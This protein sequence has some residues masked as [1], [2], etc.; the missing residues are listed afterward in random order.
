LKDG[1]GASKSTTTGSDGS[2]SIDA[3]G[4][5]APF[6]FEASG[7]IGG[8]QVVLHSVAESITSSGKVVANITPL[9]DAVV[10]NVAGEDSSAFFI[11]PDASKVTAASISAAQA[12]I[13][14]ALSS[15]LKAAGLPSDVDLLKTTFSADKTGMDAVLDVVKVS[16]TISNGTAVIQ[17]QN[18]LNPDETVTLT[19]SASPTGSITLTSIPDLTKLDAF[20]A[21]FNAAVASASAIKTTLPSVFDDNYLEDG[22]SKAD[23]LTRLQATDLLVGV[24]ASLPLIDRCNAAGD[25]CSVRMSLLYPN[26]S[27]DAFPQS[28]KRQADGSWRLYGNQ[29][30]HS[31]AI[32]SVAEKFVRPDGGQAASAVTGFQFYVDPSI[33]G[34]QSA[35]LFVQDPAGGADIELLRVKLKPSVCGQQASWLSLDAPGQASDCSNFANVTDSVITTLYQA[36]KPAPKFRVK[37]YA[38]QTYTKLAG[39]GTEG[40]GIYSNVQAPAA[41]PLNAA[42]ASAPFPS[43]TSAG[44]ANL[45][46]FGPN[47]ALTLSWTVPAQI[48][49]L[50]VSA[51]VFSDQNLMRYVSSDS[52][53]GLSEV[54]LTGGDTP[55]TAGAA[56]Y[57]SA[58]LQARD[59]DGRNYWTKYYSC[60]GGTCF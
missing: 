39:T 26:G 1:K 34:A 23:A 18:K 45:A 44:L 33:G 12:A 53:I 50:S 19:G 6:I 9:T 7:M 31:F 37:V 15:V 48:S 35:I 29:R 55:G 57:R 25:V 51:N 54:K 5:T 43:L 60:G 24:K 3:T 16:V 2:Y 42:I 20:V 59:A 13:K 49:V 36:G 27:L 32:E 52:T 30:S 47:G 21:S 41:P 40:N 58:T 28:L 11:S 46:A 10:A 22:D 8:S 17:L 4:L 56:N 14:A 38:D